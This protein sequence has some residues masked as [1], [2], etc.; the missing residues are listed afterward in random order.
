MKR[1]VGVIEYRRTLEPRV[2]PRPHEVLVLKIELGLLWDFSGAQCN[3]V[4]WQGVAEPSTNSRNEGL[5]G[6]PAKG[7]KLQATDDERARP[8]KMVPFVVCERRYALTHARESYDQHGG[9]WAL[10][11]S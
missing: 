5:S 9:P 3:V 8:D 6:R 2:T 11:Q 4:I 10:P 1:P 7:Q